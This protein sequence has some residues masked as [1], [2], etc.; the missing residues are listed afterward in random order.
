MVVLLFVRK[1]YVPT[2]FFNVRGILHQDVSPVGEPSLAEDRLSAIKI[3]GGSGY[4]DVFLGNET[5]DNK[6]V[7]KESNVPPDEALLAALTRTVPELNVKSGLVHAG[8]NKDAYFNTLRRFC[9]EYEEYI[10]EIVRFTAEENWL[11]YSVE[12][13]LLR[14]IFAN[15]GNGYLSAWAHKLELAFGEDDNAICRNETEP[16]CY[17]MYLFKEKLAAVMFL[18]T[19]DE[20]NE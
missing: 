14:G 1:A 13:R 7:G 10:R 16:F 8:K 20:N 3:D 2:R 5:V 4:A 19:D 18:V 15:M 11:D 17:A 9:D 12:L 6:S